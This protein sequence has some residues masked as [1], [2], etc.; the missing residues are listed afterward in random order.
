[1]RFVVHVAVLN[2]NDTVQNLLD[3][4]VDRL[5]DG[6][7]RV[8][9]PKA[10]LLQESSWYQ[11]ARPTRRKVLTSALAK[12]PR[13]E[14]VER[15]PHV[16][17]LEVFDSESARLAYKLA[18]TPFVVLVEDQESDGVLLDV[19]VEELGW[20][21][22]QVYWSGGRSITPPTTEVRS[23]G[24]RDAIPERIK[25]I[26]SDAQAAERPHRLFVICDSDL[27]WP[28]D[29]DIE[30]RRP[31]EAILDACATHGVPYRIWTKRSAENYIPDEVFES[32]RDDLRNSGNRERF[33]AFLRRPPK[34]R[35]HF[36]VKNGLRPEERE[37]ATAA[38]LYRPSE[39]SDLKQL[40]KRLFPRRPRP[41][42]ILVEERRT[43]F[44]ADGLRDRDGNAELD[45]LLRAISL[46]L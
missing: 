30:R 12:P 4:L 3:R 25:R 38:G 45:D 23:A 43:S 20:P 18:H 39:K 32:A 16:K 44:T 41:L 26:V 10:D 7:H 1:V 22:L 42:K 31:I 5:A 34:Q 15:G 6:A 24:G 21:E 9:V 33:N 11:N 27:R 46:E 29:N 28:G 35:D 17:T 2:G 14:Q 40:E 37:L 19:V 13:I 36:P 8:D